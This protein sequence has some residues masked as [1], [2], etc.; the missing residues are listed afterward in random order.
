MLL[1]FSCFSECNLVAH[2]L[3]RWIQGGRNFILACGIL[4]LATASGTNLDFGRL[5]KCWQFE[6]VAYLLQYWSVGDT[7]SPSGHF[8]CW[9]LPAL[10]CQ[11]V[12]WKTWKRIR[13]WKKKHIAVHFW[14]LHSS[15]APGWVQGEVRMYRTQPAEC[16][17]NSTDN[18]KLRG[19]CILPESTT[20]PRWCWGRRAESGLNSAPYRGKAVNGQEYGW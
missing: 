11:P 16:E 2:L 14:A 19:S 6:H 12:E 20:R 15:W 4:N 17:L 9:E 7:L 8:W 10:E 3:V 1:F 5:C 13:A 18:V